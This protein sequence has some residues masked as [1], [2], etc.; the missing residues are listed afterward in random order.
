[1][2]LLQNSAIATAPS[3]GLIE[4][5]SIDD[6]ESSR[7]STFDMNSRFWI[8]VASIPIHRNVKCR[9][10]SLELITWGPHSGLETEREIRRRLFTVLH[11]T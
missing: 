7:N 10:I 9:W 5:F 11:K 2:Y 8:F 3:P 1:M 6:G 4:S